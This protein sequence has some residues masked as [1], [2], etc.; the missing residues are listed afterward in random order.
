ELPPPEHIAEIQN[1]GGVKA[2][3]WINDESD[4]LVSIQGEGEIIEFLDNMDISI[5][6]NYPCFIPIFEKGEGVIVEGEQIRYSETMFV[7]PQKTPHRKLHYY[8]ITVIKYMD[9]YNTNIAIGLAT[10]PYPHFRLPGLNLY[11][12][13]YHSINGQKFNND[14][15]GIEYGPDWTKVEDTIGCGYYSDSGDVF[16][17]KNGKFLGCAFTNIKHIWFPTIGANSPCTIEINFGDNPDNEFKYKEAIGYGPGGSILLSKRRS[18]KSRNN[19]KG[20]SSE[21]KT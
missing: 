1:I 7:Q 2:W 3:Q 15:I 5:Q 4:Q 17:T 21:S 11:S 20:S 10:K 13:G 19:I 12:V 8:E 14:S 6:T 9:P 16:F 18:L